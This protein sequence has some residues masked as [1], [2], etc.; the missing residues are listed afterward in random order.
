MIEFTT[1][2]HDAIVYTDESGARHAGL[3][4]AVVDGV[5]TITG[6]GQIQR[7]ARAWLDAGNAPAVY[8]SPAPTIANVK[9]E[10]Q[11]RIIALTGATTFDGCLTKQLNASMRAS[12]L[13]NKKASGVTLT[14]E[15]QAEEVALQTLADAIKLIRARSNMIEQMDP[16][17]SDYATNETYWT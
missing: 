2:S 3:Q 16:I 11:R 10:A 12:E 13:I 14:T 9:S 8:E 6:D 7:K 5:F 1:P 4:F 17:P 15:E